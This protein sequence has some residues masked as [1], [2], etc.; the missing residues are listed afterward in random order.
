MPSV[1]HDESESRPVKRAKTSNSNSGAG[2]QFASGLLSPDSTARY[3][4]AYKDSTPYHHS[5]I[6]Q[7]FQDDLVRK[8]REEIKANLVFTEKETDIYKVK[9]TGDLANLDGLEGEELSK[10]SHVSTLRNALYSPEFR[11]FLRKVTG[12]GP[13]SGTKI[14]MSINNYTQGCHLLNHDDVIGTRSVSYI[15]YL[16]DPDEK[17]E[18]SYGGSLELY[19]VKEAWI[20]VDEPSL[21]LPPSWDQFI[22]FAVQPG[23]SFH[24][25]EEVVAEGKERLSIS[26]WFHVAQEG[27][28]GFDPHAN[29]SERNEQDKAKS[30]LEQLL[31]ETEDNFDTYKHAMSEAEEL[32]PDDISVLETLMNPQYLS[33]RTLVQVNDKFCE[34]SHIQL[35]EILRPDV[36]ESL[37]D[38]LRR[39]DVEDGISARK[40]TAHGTGTGHGWRTHGPPHRQRFMVLD[41]TDPDSGTNEAARKLR[42]VQSC[43][44][45]NAFRKWLSL[46]TSLVPTARHA[47]VR[48][49]RPGL[50]YTL[51]TSNQQPLIEVNLCMTPPDK[52]WDGG[53]V[54]GYSCFMAPHEDEDAAVYKGAQ[55]DEDDGVLLTA[56]AT[57]NEMTIVMRDPGILSFT[58][59]VAVKAGGSRW[60]CAGEYTVQPDEDAESESEN[61]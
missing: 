23:H 56:N 16:P 38:V 21:T 50:D 24:S 28:E 29:E 25:V 46:V 6:P 5:L 14:D 32:T 27:E 30:T 7:L 4:Q 53:E 3:A 1:D 40:M 47:S 39:T 37:L 10:L 61:Q 19:P 54:G 20:P 51:A 35:S 44:A 41:G 22:M 13:L 26:G 48:R 8:V 52:V 49:F 60:D 45:S 55:D 9:Q 59:Y 18:P 34:D 57:W 36:S 2:E 15:L 17:W 31:S 12:V 11:S 33:L 43:L 42:E 58:K